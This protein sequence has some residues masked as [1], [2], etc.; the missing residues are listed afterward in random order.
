MVGGVKAV[1]LLVVLVG[2]VVDDSYSPNNSN[3][4]GSLHEV[5]GA[6]GE[7]YSVILPKPDQ[8]D[9]I[10]LKAEAGDGI[11]QF[12]LAQ[13]YWNA[14]GTTRDKNQSLI[15]I[16]L[17][18]QNGVPIAQQMLGSFYFSGHKV[19]SPMPTDEVKGREWTQKAAKNGY[20]GA[21]LPLALSY[22]RGFGGPIA[23]VQAKYWYKKA[24]DSGNRDAMRELQNLS[25]Q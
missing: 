7:V 13:M 10:R 12:Q 24:A 15:W 3:S 4:S 6:D 25:N 19:G 11:A 17:S 22:H 2:C 21:F 18:A 5:R 20:P 9:T 1:I 8:F 16:K 14:I 23:L